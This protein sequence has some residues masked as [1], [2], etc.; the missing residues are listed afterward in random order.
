LTFIILFFEL[1]DVYELRCF[2]TGFFLTGC[3]SGPDLLMKL[4]NESP[5]TSHTLCGQ[6]TPVTRGLSEQE[7]QSQ[8]TCVTH[9]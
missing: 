6:V 5:H 8:M 7:D 2:D 4:L 9:R 3:V 1:C